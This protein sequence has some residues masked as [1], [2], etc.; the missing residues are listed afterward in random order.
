MNRLKKNLNNK[1][2]TL[3]ELIVAIIIIG[4]LS[5]VAVLAFNHQRRRAWEAAARADI[6][7]TITAIESHRASHRSAPERWEHV[8][9]AGGR[10]SD[11]VAVWGFY[12]GGHACA[13]T[14]LDYV[15]VT[16]HTSAPE[17]FFVFSSWTGLTDMVEQDGLQELLGTDNPQTPLVENARHIAFENSYAN[18]N[19]ESIPSE[20]LIQQ[21][22]L[23]ATGEAGTWVGGGGVQIAGGGAINQHDGWRPVVERPYNLNTVNFTWQH[24]T[25]AAIYICEY[26]INHQ[27]EWRTCEAR[28][29]GPARW[30]QINPGGPDRAVTLRLT[31]VDASGTRGFPAADT[32]GRTA[33]LDEWNE[34]MGGFG[35][36]PVSSEPGLWTRF[37]FQGGIFDTL[38]F[39]HP[40]T[41]STNGP[42]IRAWLSDF[43]NVRELLNQ[44]Y[45]ARDVFNPYRTS[46]QQSGSAAN[47]WGLGR[48]YV[49]VLRTIITGQGDITFNV[50]V[51]DM[52]Q[53]FLDG[54]PVGVIGDCCWVNRP[55]T[56]TLS[57]E[58]ILDF[59][60]V[61]GSGGEGLWTNLQPG[62]FPN[63]VVTSMFPV[64]PVQTELPSAATD[65][66][67]ASPPINGH[68]PLTP[69]NGQPL[70][71]HPGVMENSVHTMRTGNPVPF[72]Q[73]DIFTFVQS[74]TIAAGFGSNSN[75][76][77][78]VI[79]LDAN[80]TILGSSNH[81]HTQNGTTLP[82][83][84]QF[85]ETTVIGAGNQHLMPPVGTA[86]F[87]ISARWMTNGGVATLTRGTQAAPVSDTEW[88][89]W[90]QPANGRR[91]D[92]VPNGTHYTAI[93][94][95]PGV[96]FQRSTRLIPF[97][98]GAVFT[99]NQQLTPN[100]AGNSAGSV[101]VLWFNA[102]G[103]L[104]S[105][106]GFSSTAN[107]VGVRT[108]WTGTIGTGGSAQPPN[109]AA[110]FQVQA[111]YMA[112]GGVATLRQT[113]GAV[114]IAPNEPLVL[115]N[116][117]LNQT[118]YASPYWWIFNLDE[119]QLPAHL[120]DVPLRV[121]GLS[122][123]D[124][125]NYIVAGQT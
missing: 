70:M 64:A 42:A 54:R 37:I 119:F 43:Q 6:R 76:R 8:T 79:W 56:I 97:N 71:G 92:N 11:G 93:P 117:I 55:R 32:T 23:C 59:V 98:P 81:G 3:T 83:G 66:W 41:T 82:A 125:K 68:W 51:D 14:T 87:V 121:E 38:N 120:Q 57:G 69:T 72:N 50:G 22:T 36:T 26:Q 86:S 47:N 1:G 52:F 96:Q 123:L 21:P 73:G 62:N 20:S 80:G 16:Q 27:G 109:G 63:G 5:G 46:W 116:P 35:T 2:L 67:S 103:N 15:I 49:A 107:P 84:T 31:P 90:S 12:P 104:I 77:T 122:T 58:H 94:S 60:V 17:N 89:S 9:Q 34:W 40:G 61:Q 10:T 105:Q 91:P 108:N 102:D 33:T 95:V 19:R 99:W 101:I 110:F 29:T 74:G 85:T 88:W 75:P 25:G 48:D 13:A 4:V 106:N 100:D 7:T 114:T 113:G 118:R 45:T 18:E 30:V 28:G 124:P 44:P 78:W 112:N 111:R 65:Y 39:T 24:L 53:I 115:T